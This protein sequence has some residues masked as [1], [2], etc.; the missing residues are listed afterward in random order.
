MIRKNPI[1]LLAGVVC[2]VAF[3]S[4][5]QPLAAPKAKPARKTTALSYHDAWREAWEE[6]IKWTRGV[7]VAFLDS[8]PCVTNYEARLLQNPGDMANLLRPYYGDTAANTFS[9]LVY[10]HLVIAVEILAAAKSGD[11]NGVA[12]ASAAWYQNAQDIA[13]LM[14]TLNSRCWPA[15]EMYTMWKQHLDATLSEAVSHLTH[16]CTTEVTAFDTIETL[17]LEMADTFSDCIIEHFHNRFSSTPK[18]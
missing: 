11:T 17:A 8:N 4:T 9:N 15:G 12:T 14:A 3:I 13:N 7:I 10:Q 18:F 16:D 2:L 1:L 6:H 5:N